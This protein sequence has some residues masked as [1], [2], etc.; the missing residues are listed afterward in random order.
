VAFGLRV[1]F[2]VGGSIRAGCS[3]CDG[4]DDQAVGAVSCVVL[5]GDRDVL[6]SVGQQLCVLRCGGR[7]A[8]DRQVDGS[9]ILQDDKRRAVFGAAFRAPCAD[10]FAEAFGVRTS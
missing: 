4:V 6:A 1:S 5:A 8:V 7:V 3:S 2:L 10:G 9:V